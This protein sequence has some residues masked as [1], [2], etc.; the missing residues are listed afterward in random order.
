MIFASSFFIE[1][2][3]GTF[4]FKLES[5]KGNTREGLGCVC[6]D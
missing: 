3:L 5:Q 6:E 4:A 2:D 1:S